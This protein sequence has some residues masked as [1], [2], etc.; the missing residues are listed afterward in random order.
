MMWHLLCFFPQHPLHQMLQFF[1]LSGLFFI[2]FL[3][4]PS[5]YHGSLLNSEELPNQADNLI[6]DYLVSGW[7]F[8]FIFQTESVLKFVYFILVLIDYST[9][10]WVSGSFSDIIISG[11]YTKLVIGELIIQSNIM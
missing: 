3:L 10:P 6:S 7:L 8:S 1:L 4:V 9:S 2:C 11:N 5:D